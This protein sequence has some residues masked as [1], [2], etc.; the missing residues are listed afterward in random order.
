MK[1]K[2]IL[3]GLGL[4]I[5]A[6]AA[7]TTTNA[8]ADGLKQDFDYSAD[9]VGAVGGSNLYD[10]YARSNVANEVL[11]LVKHDGADVLHFG[12]T[13]NGADTTATTPKLQ[14]RDNGS[15]GNLFNQAGKNVIINTRYKTVRG[16][17]KCFYLYDANLGTIQI[18]NIKNLQH[19][20]G[21]VAN[22]QW[23][24]L[25]VV[26]AEGGTAGDK[27]YAYADGVL[28]QELAPASGKDWT[29]S[30]TEVG[31]Q[32]GKSDFTY[33]ADFYIDY[34]EIQEYA[35]ATASVEA[36][37][38]TQVGGSFELK[39]TFE[40]TPSL[41][42]Y[43]I[44]IAD[45]TVL[46]YNTQTKKF[47][48][49]K[50][51]TTTVT[52]DFVDK[53]LTDVSTTVTVEEAA[54]EILVNDVVLNE[55]FE[56]KLELNVGQKFKLDKL[57]SALPAIANNKNLAYSVVEGTDVVTIANGEI[58]GAKAGTAKVKVTAADSG[59]YNETFD[60]VVN[61]G[62][63]ELL[64]DYELTD[65]WLTPTETMTYQGWE[66]FQYT[67]QY[68]RVYTPIEVAEDDFFGKVVKFTGQG[69]SNSNEGTATG[70]AALIKHIALS[71]LTANKDYKLSGWAKVDTTGTQVAPKT[72]VDAKVFGYK[73]VDGQPEYLSG[74]PYVI[75]NTTLTNFAN[76]GWVYFEFGLINL[77]AT[78][79]DGIKIELISWNCQQ[80]TTAYVANVALEEQD[81]VKNVG[82][83]VEVNQQA[84]QEN[85]SLTLG[86]TLQLN[87][88]PIPSTSVVT[89]IQYAS[90]DATKVS[91]S[92]AGLITAVAVGTATVTVTD[93]KKTVEINVTVTNPA[94]KVETQSSVEVFAGSYEEL[95]LVTTP[96][97]ST[98]TF[99]AT[100]S[101]TGLVVAVE[102][103][104]LAL[105]ANEVG[106]Y[107]VEIV[108]QD[109]AEVKFVLTVL[110]K[111]ATATDLTLTESSKTLAVGATVQI[112]ATVTPNGR[113]VTYLSSDTTVATVSA[114]GL[115]T[116]VKAGT[117]TITVAADDLSETF[118]VTVTQPATSVT[119]EIAEVTLK[120]GETH[121]VEATVS[122]ADSTDNV[123]YTSSDANVVTVDKDGK[124]T[125][126]GAGEATVTVTAGNK[127]ATVK[128]TVTKPGCGGSILGA[129]SA[130]VA[131]GAVVV[132][133]KKRK[134]EDK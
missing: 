15:A 68:G 42:N 64:N 113:P 102:G 29:G 45:E 21:N 129:M 99:T 6:L 19:G 90:T 53:L 94:T 50:T 67:G 98:S 62:N 24:D 97:N 51:G 80:N 81:T 75:Q 130:V 73:L 56:D 52:F 60:V 3:L 32:T 85:V 49:L 7:T 66:S 9:G 115:V 48:G 107:T 96:T 74:E 12:V 95:D 82:W 117:A 22:S 40:G 84:V 31:F 16:Y 87:V 77:D 88:L 33:E 124:I 72:R 119:V 23:H 2:K 112:Q 70:G 11:E 14:I 4:T 118:T 69:T 83:A 133:A 20:N 93:G 91:V 34:I 109:N 41:E 43:S 44:K 127:T 79:M 110:V 8:A 126:V 25:S 17:S 114:E 128:V 38:T 10:I 58:T 101:A 122:P 108:S 28:I 125:A 86:S 120:V 63:F 111:E 103:S 36:T 65:K 71:E 18:T 134:D 104:K 46:G 123:T 76:T 13:G 54:A 37:K 121:E 1:I 105:Q 89:G 78:K 106:T 116:A 92:E 26:I 57:F 100:S 59:A 35:S 5:G 61:K 30:L 55:L 47:E 39:P 131:L 27:I 132:L